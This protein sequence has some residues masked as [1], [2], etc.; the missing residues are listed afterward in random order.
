MNAST[1]ASKRMSFKNTAFLFS[2]RKKH[3][4]RNGSVYCLSIHCDTKWM[5]QVLHSQLISFENIA[6]MFSFR[7]KHQCRNDNV[8]CLS[9]H[10]DSKSM[11]QVLHAQLFSFENIPSQKKEG[12]PPEKKALVV[13][14]QLHIEQKSN[15]WVRLNE[16]RHHHSSFR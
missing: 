12:W 5:H 13:L 6:F 9:I 1:I 11:H 2:F 4:C 15:P 3:Q 7:G 10:Y 16:E 8:Y 14:V